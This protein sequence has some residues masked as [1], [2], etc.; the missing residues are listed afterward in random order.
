MSAGVYAQFHKDITCWAHFCCSV[1]WFQG[2]PLWIWQPVREFI[3]G[4]YWL[5]ISQWSVVVV[6]TCLSRDRAPKAS[7]FH[8]NMSVYIAI[9]PILLSWPCLG[10]IVSQLTFSCPCACSISIS[11]F[12]D[13]PWATDTEAVRSDADASTGAVYYMINWSLN[14]VQLWFSVMISIWCKMMKGGSYTHLLRN[15]AGPANEQ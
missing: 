8:V 12:R 7:P 6:C 11:L 2:W 5:S 13:V 9:V 3:P 10:D 4:K 14:W 15:Y 1:C